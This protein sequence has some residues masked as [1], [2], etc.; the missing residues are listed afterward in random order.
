M[1]EESADALKNSRLNMLSLVVGGDDG[2]KVR[3]K[4]ENQR[5]DRKGQCARAAV[6]AAV[7]NLKTAARAFD[8]GVPRDFAHLLHQPARL[9]CHQSVHLLV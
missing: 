7:K 2:I 9:T 5:G 4:I 1:L 3:R 6:K 8:H